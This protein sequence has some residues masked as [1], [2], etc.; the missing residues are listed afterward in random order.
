MDWLCAGFARWQEGAEE[1]RE[2]LRLDPNNA[3][4][5]KGL[6]IAMIKQGLSGEMPA[7]ILEFYRSASEPQ[8]PD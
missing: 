8:A 5:A 2:V 6:Y 4:A 1:L 7:S 3:E